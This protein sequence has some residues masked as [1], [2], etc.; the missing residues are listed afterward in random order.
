[1]KLNSASGKIEVEQTGSVNSISAKSASG[2]I[3]AI[4]EKA[5]E[6]DFSTASGKIEVTANEIKSISSTSA[7][8]SIIYDLLEVPSKCKANSVSGK[9]TLK[10]PEDAGFTLKVDTVSGTF[11]YDFALKKSGNYYV[12][13]DG[14][15]KIDIN[16]A[17]GNVKVISK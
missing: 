11:D 4:L 17:S 7:S 13:G 14:D 1:M 9:V 10:F 12:C 5:D 16:T 3:N 15:A 6:A 2:K 8:G